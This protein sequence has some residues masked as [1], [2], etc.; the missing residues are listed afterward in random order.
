[1]ATSLIDPTD[2]QLF[3]N[4]P[5]TT[6]SA[7]L[8]FRT[9][10]TKNA[11]NRLTIWFKG[12]LGGGTLNLQTLKPGVVIGEDVED[13]WANTQDVIISPDEIR[14]KYVNAYCR[15]NLTGATSATLEAHLRRNTN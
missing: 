5:Q 14:V 7:S 4:D 10:N 6:N 12:D 1:M 9:D 2:T 11:F 15:L 8:A 13:D 3:P